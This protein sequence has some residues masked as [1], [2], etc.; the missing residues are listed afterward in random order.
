LPPHVAQTF[1]E[2][3][4]P[5]GDAQ[6]E[7]RRETAIRRLDALYKHLTAPGAAQGGAD[8]MESFLQR[9]S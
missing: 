3:T 5:P 1:G 6:T 8:A 9:Q 7:A 4:A 2:A